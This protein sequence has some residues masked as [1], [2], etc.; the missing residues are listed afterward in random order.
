MANKKKTKKAKTSKTKKITKKNVA[1]KVAKKPLA[2]K[3]A[4]PRK[5]VSKKIVAKKP[6]RRTGFNAKSENIDTV[7]FQPAGLGARSGGQ[8]GDL[9]GLS[10]IEGADSES[11]GELLEE[12]NAF[13][14]ELVKGIEDVR[15]ADEDEIITHEVL[16]DDV[17]EE[18]LDENER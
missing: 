17:P 15:D 2:R 16:E 14:A 10:R 7:V 18:Y 12:G 13:E 9:Q 1:K 6:S 4:A 5:V 8:S 11:V 3:K